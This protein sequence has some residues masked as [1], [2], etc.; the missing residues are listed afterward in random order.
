[1]IGRKEGEEGE[2]GEDQEENG[3][4]NLRIDFL[5]SKMPQVYPYNNFILFKPSKVISLV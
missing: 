4:K 5:H 2:E 3:V 1:M